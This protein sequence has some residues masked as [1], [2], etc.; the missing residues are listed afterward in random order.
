MSLP[1]ELLELIFNFCYLGSLENDDEEFS[2]STLFP[3]HLAEVDPLWKDIPEYW[4][5]VISKSSATG[6]EDAEAMS[7][8]LFGVA[9]IRRSGANPNDAAEKARVKNF[10][11]LLEPHMSQFGAS[12]IDVY[13]SSSLP[14]VTTDFIHVPPTSTYLRDLDDNAVSECK[15][16]MPSYIFMVVLDGYTFATDQSW[17]HLRKVLLLA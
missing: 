17:L 4:T 16:Q 12:L 2:L 14:S 10:M 8:K 11:D 15:V 5:R 1:I 7:S 6:E 9:I 13:A 3:Y